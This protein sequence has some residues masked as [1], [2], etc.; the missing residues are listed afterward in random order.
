LTY[1]GRIYVP[2]IDSL[3]GKVIGL[4]HENPQS[5]DFGALKTTEQVSRNFYWPVMDSRVS[6]DAHGCEVCH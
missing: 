6:K 4:F 5:G 2:V 1:V 3:H